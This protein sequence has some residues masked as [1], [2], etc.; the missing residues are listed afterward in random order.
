MVRMAAW[1]SSLLLAYGMHVGA[2]ALLYLLGSAVGPLLYTYPAGRAAYN[3]VIAGVYALAFLAST[4]GVL[5]FLGIDIDSR[6][7]AR[8]LAGP[9]LPYIVIV[10]VLVASTGM[11]AQL[12]TQLLVLAAV[13]QKIVM[14]VISP[15]TAYLR[16]LGYVMGEVRAALV[17]LASGGAAYV[18][19]THALPRILSSTGISALYGA[20][21]GYG[22]VL[23]G[24]SIPV[25][26]LAIETAALL[27]LRRSYAV[28]F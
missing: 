14:Y 21:H 23:I 26:A 24:L 9:T 7:G 27:L 15:V 4:L 28:L 25:T 22:G 20:L 3:V 16:A 2:F 6:W 13:Y 10:A 19:C 18:F 5:W 8:F 17:G 11:P 1:L 12:A